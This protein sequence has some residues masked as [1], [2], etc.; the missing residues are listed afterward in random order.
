MNGAVVAAGRRLGIPTPVNE[1][2]VEVGHA[3]E[4]GDLE[5]ALAA[6]QRMQR[7]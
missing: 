1:A 4:R 3:I 5:P 7:G 2:I 6:L